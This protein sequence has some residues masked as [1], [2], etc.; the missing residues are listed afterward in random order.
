MGGGETI[1][2]KGVEGQQQQAPSYP[3]PQHITP[4]LTLQAPLSRRGNGPGLVL[5][6]NHYAQIEKKE[7][8]L[9]PEPLRKWAEEG[10]CVVQVSLGWSWGLE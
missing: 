1:T 3:A 4:H 10:F 6:L 5:V 8:E 9:D 2:A 7:G